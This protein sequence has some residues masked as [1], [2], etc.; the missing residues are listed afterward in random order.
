MKFQKKICTNQQYFPFHL[1]SNSSS[2]TANSPEDSHNMNFILLPIPKFLHFFFSFTFNC[3]HHPS[4]FCA[5]PFKHKIFHLECQ[6]IE[7]K[8]VPFIISYN[9]FFL[10]KEIF[11]SCYHAHISSANIACLTM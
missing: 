5:Y 8:S 2:M 10:F 11:M 3:C 7:T 9:I 4:Y 6:P 1:M